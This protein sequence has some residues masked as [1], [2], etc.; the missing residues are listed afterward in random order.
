MLEGF[1]KNN[2]NQKTKIQNFADSNDL[3]PDK[4]N[5]I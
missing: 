4:K 1:N 3:N 2:K 5:E